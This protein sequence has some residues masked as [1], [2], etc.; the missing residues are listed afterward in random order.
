MLAGDLYL[1]D[2]PELAE[3]ML[4]AAELM[5]AFNAS[6]ARDPVERRPSRSATPSTASSAE[7]PTRLCH[8]DRKADP[9]IKADLGVSYAVFGPAVA[10]SW[11]APADEMGGSSTF[12]RLS[13]R[14]ARRGACGKTR[15]VPQNRRP[16]P[17]PAEGGRTAGVGDV[18]ASY[19]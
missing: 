11:S 16:R 14:I 15:V 13:Q 12:S 2:D 19:R 6:S 10:G 1:A 9:Q 7:T 3:L 5:E 4:G 8:R 18:V 17:Q